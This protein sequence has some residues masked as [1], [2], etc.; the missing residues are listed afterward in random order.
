MERYDVTLIVILIMSSLR[1]QP[2]FEGWMGRL[3]RRSVK[4][5]GLLRD[6]DDKVEKN[7]AESQGTLL[8]RVG[9]RC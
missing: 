3:P 6:Q 9:Q 5:R 2:T 7:K 4:I 8:E 1:S